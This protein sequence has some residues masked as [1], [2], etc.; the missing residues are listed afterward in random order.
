MTRWL[1]TFAV[2]VLFLAACRNGTIT[3]APATPAPT[4]APTQTAQATGSPDHIV[5]AFGDSIAGEPGSICPD[6]KPFVDRY[7]EALAASTA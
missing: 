4:V 3:S 7:G 6:C 5:A 2:A 1:V